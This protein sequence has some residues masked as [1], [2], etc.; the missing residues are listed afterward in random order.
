MSWVTWEEAENPYEV[1]LAHLEGLREKDGTEGEWEVQLEE[2]VRTFVGD[3]IGE[4]VR[5]EGRVGMARLEVREQRM[6]KSENEL[7]VQRCVAKVSFF[8]L[9]EEGGS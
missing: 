2:N 3:G 8:G 4:A 1:L 7:R 9:A 6:R 5:G